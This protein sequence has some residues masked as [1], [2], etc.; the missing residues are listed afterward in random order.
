MPY[1]QTGTCWR[2]GQDLHQHDYA[3]EASCPKCQTPTHVCRNCRFFSAQ[4]PAQCTEPVA[5]AVA[6]KQRAN[7]CGYFEATNVARD[8]SKD[9]ATLRQAA[10]DLFDL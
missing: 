7:F 5:D 2:C 3:R 10:D 6:D 8:N 9:A 4:A 1:T